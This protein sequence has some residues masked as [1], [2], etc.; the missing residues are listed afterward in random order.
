MND[1]LQLFT[2]V[3]SLFLSQK[4][5][6]LSII[7]IGFELMLIQVENTL[8]TALSGIFVVLFYLFYGILL[9]LN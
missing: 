5:R 7:L 4:N 3:L 1:Q 6:E 2:L 9:L 8:Q